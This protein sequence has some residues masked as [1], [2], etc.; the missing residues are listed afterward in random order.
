MVKKDSEAAAVVWSS[1]KG[2]GSASFAAW[3]QDGE[4]YM[5]S[6]DPGIIQAVARKAISNWP[7]R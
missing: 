6:V 2:R 3:L 1:G 5:E 4:R 7:T